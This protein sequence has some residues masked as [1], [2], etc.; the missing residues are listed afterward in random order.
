MIVESFSAMFNRLRKRLEEG[1]EI[2][3]GG[4]ETRRDAF[5]LGRWVGRVV[6]GRGAKALSESLTKTTGGC[7]GDPT[8]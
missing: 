1:G 6:G 7:N 4:E 5:Y 2:I 8:A 3:T